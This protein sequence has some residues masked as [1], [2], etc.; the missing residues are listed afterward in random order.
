MW[1]TFVED[2]RV[3]YLFKGEYPGSVRNFSD[4]YTAILDEFAK[5][6]NPNSILHL[7]FLARMTT[8]TE[9][10]KTSNFER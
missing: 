5:K 3:E 6:Y 8:A 9:H 1:W 4:L 7:L 2:S 10:T